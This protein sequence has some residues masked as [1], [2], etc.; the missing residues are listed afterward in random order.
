MIN[1]ATTCT[2]LEELNNRVS[3]SVEPSHPILSTLCCS[4]FEAQ[5]K[6]SRDVWQVVK[7]LD[8]ACILLYT[9]VGHLLWIT[10]EKKRKRCIL[11][12]L[13]GIFVDAGRFWV[14]VLIRT[15]LSKIFKQYCCYHGTH[16]GMSANHVK[17]G[18]SISVNRSF[19]EVREPTLIFVI[20]TSTINTVMLL[21]RL[22][23][24]ALDFIQ[25]FVDTIHHQASTMTVKFAQFNSYSHLRHSCCNRRVIPVVKFHCTSLDRRSA[26][27]RWTT[28]TA[29][30][31]CASDIA[32]EK[33]LLGGCCYF[34]TVLIQIP[35]ILSM[36]QISHHL[37]QY[38][39]LKSSHFHGF[40]EHCPK[41][42]LKIW[43][44][45]LVTSI[46]DLTFQARYYF[47]EMS[48]IRIKVSGM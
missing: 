34:Y 48:A 13:L 42:S 41:I 10:P 45:W 1:V 18:I 47:H 5:K 22:V 31:W 2:Q 17:N 3:S 6:L 19:F 24:L 44:A 8:S 9:Y 4:E 30:T 20:Q 37:F 35:N 15:V 33:L 36:G 14:E 40:N 32:K 7:R 12:L 23:E 39:P 26:V 16:R 21:W 46:D 29:A 27:A 28:K 25:W 43:L 11:R 38:L